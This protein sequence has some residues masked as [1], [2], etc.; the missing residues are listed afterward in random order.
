MLPLV[1][2]I[3][4]MFVTPKKNREIYNSGAANRINNAKL[5]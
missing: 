2:F 5:W 1:L 3:I 4:S